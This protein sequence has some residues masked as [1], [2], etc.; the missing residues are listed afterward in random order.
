MNRLMGWK[1]SFYWSCTDYSPYIDMQKAYCS[2]NRALLWTVCRHYGLSD[3]IV[4]M[5]KLL[6]KNIKAQVRINDKLSD[7]FDIET[8]VMHGGIPSPVLFNILFNFIIQRVIEEARITGLKLAY[9]SGDFFH[10]AQELMYADDLVAM[11]DND[12]DLKSFVRVFEKVTQER[13]L[14]MSIK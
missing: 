5:L 4:R 6:H 2:V 11:C 8:G 10:S 9:G 13:G 3:K 12:A 1:F 7:P 14:T